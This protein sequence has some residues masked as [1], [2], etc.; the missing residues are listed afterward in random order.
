MWH[1]ADIQKLHAMS[2]IQTVSQEEA[3]RLFRDMVQPHLQAKTA[4]VDGLVKDFMSFYQ[5]IRI[6]GADL[7]EDGDM[8]LLEWG[9]NSPHMINTFVDFRE[10]ADDDV[11]FSDDEFEWLG[12]TRQIFANAHDPEAEF[13]DEAVGLCVFI[14]FAKARDDEDAGDN[15]WVPTPDTLP[16]KLKAFKANTFV[17]KQLKAKPTKITAFVSGIG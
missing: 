5:D 16:A 2:K 13:D 8:L 14:Y 3:I 4:N 17:A 1:I 9:L 7:E 10:A 15:L 12:L 11:E 6:E